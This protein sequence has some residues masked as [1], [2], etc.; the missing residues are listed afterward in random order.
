MNPVRFDQPPLPN[1]AHPAERGRRLRLRHTRTMED[2]RSVHR[3]PCRPQGNRTSLK[4]FQHRYSINAVV[5]A[6]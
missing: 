4:P 6:F 2:L 3:E 1:V 5:D